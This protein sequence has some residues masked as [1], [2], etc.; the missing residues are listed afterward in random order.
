MSCGI[1]NYTEIAVYLFKNNEASL[2]LPEVMK[3]Y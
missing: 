1:E 3:K 2:D